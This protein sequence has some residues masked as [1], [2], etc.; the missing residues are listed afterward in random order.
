M[1]VAVVDTSTGLRDRALAAHG[2]LPGAFRKAMIPPMYAIDHPQSLGVAS[3]GRADDAR[4]RPVSGTAG[5]VASS[6]RAVWRSGIATRPVLDGEAMVAH[7]SG[8]EG[9]DDFGPDHWRAP[10][11]LLVDALNSEADLNPI[12]RTLAYGQLMKVLRE[13]LRAH[14]LWRTHPEILG[15]PLGSPIIVLG[16]MRSGTT[17]IQRL[18]AC[19]DRLVHTRLFE[20]LSPVPQRA[21]GPADYRPLQAAAGL[22][23][24]HALNPALA[25]VHPSGAN[26]PDEEFG[27]FSFAF[28]GAQ[29]QA[30]WRIPAFARWWEA[31]D[32]IAVYGDFRRLLQT[33]AWTRGG[34]SDRPWVLKAPQFMEEL[35][36]LLAVFPDAR[37][38][39]LGRDAVDVVASSCSLVWQQQRI[40]S[41]TPDRHWI[42][43]E[44]L[45]KT[46][47]R[48]RAAAASRA[49]RPDVAQLAIDFAAVDRDWRGEI[50]RIYAFL[51]L[52][53]T[54]R[55][56]AAMQAYLARATGHRGHRYTLEEFGLTREDVHRA[57]PNGA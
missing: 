16:S 50:E 49:G 6:L 8:L 4:A 37:L 11:A 43:R 24:L 44:W 20:S 30:Q 56:L 34:R 7:A 26:L 51:G 57:L 14:A 47:H 18:L 39:C 17:R 28:S 5:F 31:Q 12:G 42:G 23:F 22:A 53:P 19:D 15:T 2:A 10:F 40:Q 36:A 41:N 25:A 54:S 21:R 1:S 13:R 45:H 27:L 35:D 46:T 32:P 48:V 55:A 9:H 29:F 38:L 33:I 3:A 52:E